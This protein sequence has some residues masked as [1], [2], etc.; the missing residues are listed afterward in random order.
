[1]PTCRVSFVQP[2][3]NERASPMSHPA[4]TRGRGAVITGAASGIGLAMAER[5]ARL[6][7][8]ICLADVKADALETAAASVAG[9]AA[10]AEDVIAV[11]TDV[12][13]LDQI[14][15]LKETAY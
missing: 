6:G 15:R 5:L 7:M 12:S 13:R 10:R 1:M 14:Q 3:L 9:L 2:P 8:K 4:L 11:P